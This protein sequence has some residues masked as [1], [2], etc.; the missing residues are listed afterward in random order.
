VHWLSSTTIRTA[1][2]FTSGNVN[3]RRIISGATGRG[4]KPGKALAG[5]V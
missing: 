1:T 3:E 2:A 5:L 4:L